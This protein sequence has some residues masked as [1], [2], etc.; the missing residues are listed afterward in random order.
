[1]DLEGNFLGQIT[2]EPSSYGFYSW[3]PVASGP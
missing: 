3:A 2:N 1:M